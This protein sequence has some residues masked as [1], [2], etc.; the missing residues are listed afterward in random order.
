VKKAVIALVLLSGSLA[1]ASAAI[2]DRE[3]SYPLQEKEEIRRTLKSAD[4]SHPLTLAVDNVFGGIDVQVV[5]GTEVELIAS[6]TIRAKTQEK[7]ARAKVDVD[8]KITQQGNDI[9]LYVDGPFRC[10]VQDCKGL[11]WRNWGYEVAYDFRLRVPRR[12]NLTLRTV[13]RGS[14]TVRG[15]EGDFDVSNVNGPV[16]LEAVAGAGSADTVN[17]DVRV[18]FVRNP[19]SA[20]SFETVNGDIRMAFAAGLAADFMMK[21][22]HGEASSDFE[23]IRLPAEPIKRETR[24][25]KTVFRRGGFTGVRIG[26]GGPE[27]H[28]ETLNG[29]ILIQKN[30]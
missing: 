23:T 2:R 14:I 19:A 3:S 15:V 29:D 12:T 11:R 30:K 1:A 8:L 13:N 6:K 10:Q 17:G 18:A 4:P 16:T 27:I 24:E 20:C 7:I 25:G 26:R 28:C 5:D 9:D 22:M 21:T